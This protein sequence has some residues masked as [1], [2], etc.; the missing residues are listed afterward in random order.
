MRLALTGTPGAGKS[1]AAAHLQ[2]WFKIVDLNTLVK[3]RFNLGLDGGC[4]VADLAGL[5]AEINPLRGDVLLVGHF[6][7][8]LPVDAVI[9][10]RT[11]PPELKRR[12]EARGYPQAKVQENL[13]AEAIDV[14]LVEAFERYPETTFEI[15]T[16][17]LKPQETATKILEIK[18]ALE[19]GEPEKLEH[20]KPGTLD[21]IDTI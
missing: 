10:L 12:L 3:E 14:I 9:V 21:W 15:N 8:L 4:L 1:S 11:H 19:K 6:S 16:T 2:D 20:Y 13:E 5:E 18:K 17:R 7:H